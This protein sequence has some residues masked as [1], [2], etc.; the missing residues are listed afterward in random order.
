MQIAHELDAAERGFMMEGGTESEDYLKYI[1]EDSGNVAVDGHFSIQVG[2]FST[3][4]VGNAYTADD[5][6]ADDSDMMYAIRCQMKCLYTSRCS[7]KHWTS[8]ALKLFPCTALPWR[9]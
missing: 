9:P 3:G 7:A 1:A 6:A 4:C 8:G 2:G 5:F